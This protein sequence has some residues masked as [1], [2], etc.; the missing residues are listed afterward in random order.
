MAEI[1]EP[2]AYTSLPAAKQTILSFQRIVQIS[3]HGNTPLA[4][5]GSNPLLLQS[6]IWRVFLG[7]THSASKVPIAPEDK[8]YKTSQSAMWLYKDFALHTPKAE[9]CSHSRPPFQATSLFNYSF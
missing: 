1:T 6:S 7:K 2:E 4:Q 3:L 5:R 8:N 9:D